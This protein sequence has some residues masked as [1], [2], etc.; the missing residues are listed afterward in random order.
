MSY[1]FSV[2]V[3]IS[4]CLVFVVVLGSVCVSFKLF[5]DG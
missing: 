3:C 2:S 1:L 4:R 5:L